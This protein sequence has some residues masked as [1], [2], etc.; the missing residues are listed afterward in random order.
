MTI[1]PARQFATFHEVVKA[2]R[3]NL[4]QGVWDYVVGGTDTET[5][6]RR[7]RMAL[8]S[9][10][11]RPRVMR[12][13]SK[14]TAKAKFLG[15][16]LR[17][18]VILAPIG[19]LESVHEDGAAASAK[20]SE[21]FN[22]MHMVSSRC[23]PGLEATAKAAD[24]HRIFQLYVRGDQK[25]QDDHVKRAID[26][27]Y[28]AFAVTID[29]DIYTRRERDHANRYFHKTRQQAI[30]DPVGVA[31]TKAFQAAYDWDN[32]KHFKDK[33][34]LPFILKGIGSVE[35]A[36]TAVE[37]GVDAI[38]VSNHGGRALDTGR[39]ALDVLPEI[40][41]AVD[42]RAKIV[43]DGSITRGSDIVKAMILG[44]DAVGVGRAQCM[45]L[46]AAG[47]PG[48]LRVLELLEEEI[49]ICF[50]LMG[51][52][53]WAELDTSYLC[54]AEPVTAPHVF[55]Q[56]PMVAFEPHPY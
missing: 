25:W 1:E 15:R 53:N 20:A 17:M 37:H 48:L 8:D 19:S 16:D 49:L 34:D 33:F 39:G 31:R 45:G 24:N 28:L 13:V 36:V 29:L 43:Y 26:S 2:A 7:N 18:P 30:A 22:V 56:H 51:V 9:I 54:K 5:T 21:I 23:E 35:D 27:G 14:R 47:V 46:A 6:L 50:G 10:A 41:A 52:N 3:N 4:K 44:A 32:V 38:Y 55:S 40:V 42:C 12:D 11:F